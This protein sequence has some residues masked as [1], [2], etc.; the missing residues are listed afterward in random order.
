MAMDSVMGVINHSTTIYRMMR[1]ELQQE[2]K[3]ANN[4]KCKPA[5]WGGVAN[6][7]EY[8]T[9]VK[10]TAEEVRDCALQMNID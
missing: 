7:I 9:G 4:R 1:T 5:E 2:Q 6:Y 8:A 10:A 3:H